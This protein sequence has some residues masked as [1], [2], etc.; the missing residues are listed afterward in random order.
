M[1]WHNQR[2]PTTIAITP[3]LPVWPLPHCHSSSECRAWLRQST[4]AHD[5][6]RLRKALMK[7]D[8][9]CVGKYILHHRIYDTTMG[10]RKRSKT[11][12][13]ESF[14]RNSV[15]NIPPRGR[16]FH[17][18]RTRRSAK[19]NNRTQG[20]RQS[21]S[22]QFCTSKFP[23]IFCSNIIRFCTDILRDYYDQILALDFL[24]ELAGRAP[25]RKTSD[26]T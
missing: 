1:S 20:P 2:S 15:V 24:F 26:R 18:K 12:R 23:V 22:H 10:R 13:L 16:K 8:Y 5:R 19:E 4:C 14:H 17:L 3:L 25:P 6:R 11:S 7:T 21:D 9:R